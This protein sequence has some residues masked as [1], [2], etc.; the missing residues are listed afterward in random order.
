M[1]KI[2]RD[3]IPRSLEK[4]ALANEPSRRQLNRLSFCIILSFSCWSLPYIP[5]DGNYR[6]RVIHREKE[7]PG[8][9]W[10][11]GAE[12]FILTTLWGDWISFIWRKEGADLIVKKGDDLR[13]ID[14]WMG[15]VGNCV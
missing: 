9:L 6:E 3:L 8:E 1:Q 5:K 15:K 12:I 2:G 10:A 4:G 13:K 11:K 14:D 7:Y